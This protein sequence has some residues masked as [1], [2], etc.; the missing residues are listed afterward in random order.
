MTRAL[1]VFGKILAC[2]LVIDRQTLK[3]KGSAFVE[4]KHEQAAARAIEN[5]QNEPGIAVS[6]IPIQV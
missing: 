4:F 5:S 1:G 3:F 2:R 6:G